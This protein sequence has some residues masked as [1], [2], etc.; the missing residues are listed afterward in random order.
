MEND[1]HNSHEN[2]NIDV[3]QKIKQNKY[4][5]IIVLFLILV[6]I[7]LIFFLIEKIIFTILTIVT[8]TPIISFPLQI[9][10]HLLL[11][12]Y[13]ILQ[14]AFAGYNKIISRSIQMNYAK[15]KIWPI[16]EGF[17]DLHELFHED[18]T[19]KIDLK[20]LSKIKNVLK[21][22]KSALKEEIKLYTKMKDKFNH[23]TIDQEKYLHN[24][25]VLN[26]ILNDENLDGFFNNIYNV[27]K[28]NYNKYSL[29]EIPKEEKDN[30]KNEISEKFHIF[31]TIAENTHCLVEQIDDFFGEEYRCCHP[32]YLRNCFKNKLFASIEQMHCEL[33]NFYHFEE[34]EFI[35][36]DNC[37]LEY[38]IIRRDL[39]VEQ[40]K[41]M[42]ICG[43]NGVPFQMFMRTRRFDLYLDYNIDIL[44]WNYRGYGFS[45]G[46]PS[47]SNLRS[48]VLELF[49]K[50][51]KEYSYVRFAVHGISMGGIP[52]CHL[53][54]HRREIELLICDRNFGKLDNITQGFPHG[55]YLFI[56]YKYFFFQ[57]SDNVDNFI[58][59]RC[60][61]IVINDPKD[62]IVSEVCSLK[63]LVSAKLCEDFLE[64]KNDLTPSHDGAPVQIL[65]NDSDLYR[66]APDQQ[67]Q[68]PMISDNIKTSTQSIVKNN[69]KESKSLIPKTILDKIFNSVE[70]KNKFIQHFLN[71]TKILDNEKL[72]S[73]NNNNSIIKTILMKFGY[74]SIQY[75]NLKEE[76]IINTSV[77]FDLI[78]NKINE[79][80]DKI[81]SAGDHLSRIYS[82]KRDYTKK[83]FID[84]F[85][86]NM[87]IWGTLSPANSEHIHS[88]KYIKKNF[89]AA[90]QMFEE[91]LNSEDIANNKECFLVIG[92][93]TLF[94]Y[95]KTIHES[96]N[97]I[98]V[99]TD[100]GYI[101]LGEQGSIEE[102]NRDNYENV[103]KEKRGNLVWINCGHNGM[104][105]FDERKL[106]IH[107]F[108]ESNFFMDRNSNTIE[109][110]NDSDINIIENGND[111]D[112]NNNKI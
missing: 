8:F 62:N 89:D 60:D 88:T 109:N 33:E 85:F 108:E 82:I 92:I 97:S 64:C 53:A 52:C 75:S 99:K 95:F 71:L 103:L 94:E 4:L 25:S 13:I 111:N 87:F 7:L 101:K 56:L 112:I 35:T 84:N 41:L 77:V 107:Y 19:S 86:N 29:D 36:K 2:E 26:T 67:N 42:I 49:D 96:I 61:K 6:I 83:I 48:D 76:D 57:S 55:K 93:T 47:Y 24:I 9:F 51:K 11:I 5:Y 68:F 3:M 16:R 50:I 79:I 27:I 74:K 44:C 81:Q 43:P 110:D 72:E 80:L 12:R 70:G 28:D 104:L 63:T 73:K 18:M 66:E 17:K 65:A 23:L 91:F 22:I 46:A 10:L 40:K 15:T 98:E 45:K 38:I 100:N 59:A 31:R 105:N 54:N 30:I 106:F 20:Y 102:S 58:N 14:I 32:R 78:K 1:N 69:N 21:Y 90:I 34:K 39:N 37:K